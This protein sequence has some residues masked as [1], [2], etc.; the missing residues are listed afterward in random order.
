MAETMFLR[1]PAALLLGALLGW[2]ARRHV[3][4]PTRALFGVAA[5]VLAS[6]VMP[7]WMLPV[8]MDRAEAEPLLR[9]A[10]DASLAAAGAATVLCFATWAPVLRHLWMLE[11]IGM[12]VRFAVWYGM[13]PGAL[14]TAWDADA[15][16]AVGLGL[17]AAALALGLLWA[18]R[19]W[20]A[21]MSRCA[22]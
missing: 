6:C 10:R 14:C 16:P 1:L 7:F 19:G 21:G 20:R 11:Q 22:P 18:L 9:L 12:L 3:G 8:L 17:L 13:A 15:Q 5:L 2:A 4:A